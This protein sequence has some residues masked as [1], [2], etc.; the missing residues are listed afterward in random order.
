MADKIEVTHGP[1]AEAPAERITTGPSFVPRVDVVERPESLVVLADMPG[2]SRDDVSV[3][4][5]KGVLTMDGEVCPEEEGGGLT[6][7]T[8]E[9]E[10][11]HFHRAFEVGEGLD[12]SG[13]E[14]SMKDGVLRLVIPKREDLKPHRIEIKGQ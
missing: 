5:E 8:Q 7:H 2:V 11:G 6:L 14:A 4:L 9:Y 12:P 13:V 3:V 1:S 10:V